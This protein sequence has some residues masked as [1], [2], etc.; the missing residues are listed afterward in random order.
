MNE[1]L[2]FMNFLDSVSERDG[3]R[4]LRQNKYFMSLCKGDDI[5][6]KNYA[7]ECLYLLF[8]VYALLTPRDAHRLIWNRGVH[9]HGVP[10][11]NIALVLEV[12]MSNLHLKQ[13]IKNL[14]VNVTETAV[15]RICKSEQSTRKLL[16]VV[17]KEIKKKIKGILPQ[18][19][20]SERRHL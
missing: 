20:Q 3:D 2:F 10:G 19:W 8:Q 13:A 7:I 9:N 1:G 14:G 11:A 17:D 6:C 18:L 12:E 4:I 15:A 16:S 5:H